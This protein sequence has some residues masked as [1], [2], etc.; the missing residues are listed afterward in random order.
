MFLMEHVY[1]SW[2][3]MD[4]ES[5]ELLVSWSDDPISLRYMLTEK[6]TLNNLRMCF[7]FLKIKQRGNIL[8]SRLLVST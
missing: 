7:S 1:L 3:G 2:D 6:K 8:G 4:A 5:R